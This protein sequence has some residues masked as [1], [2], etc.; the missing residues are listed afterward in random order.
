MSDAVCCSPLVLLLRTNH[1]DVSD[2]VVH[3]WQGRPMITKP[4]SSP[5]P[6]PKQKQKKKRQVRRTPQVWAP[7]SVCWCLATM[8]EIHNPIKEPMRSERICLSR[9]SF[10]TFR[11]RRDAA[12]N[13]PLCPPVSALIS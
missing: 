3:Q 2:G 9:S 12:L 11:G 7:L 6:Y 4:P 13:C 10:Y 1:R 8:K 5:T